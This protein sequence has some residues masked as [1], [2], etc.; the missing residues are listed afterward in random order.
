VSVKDSGPGIPPEH[1][2]HLFERF[3]RI[4]KSR[5]SETGGTGLG[6]AICKGVVQAH[7]G[8]I[9]VSSKVGLGTTFTVMLPVAA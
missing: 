5:A 1:L 8:Q 2:E 6:L 4:D 3:Y 7:G 9:S